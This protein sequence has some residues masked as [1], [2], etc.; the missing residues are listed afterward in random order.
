MTKIVI[1]EAYRSPIG[2]FGGAFQHISATEINSQLIAHILKQSGLQGDDIDEV[3]V[4]N[5]LQ[6]GLGQNPA[7][8]SAITGGVAESVPA[9]T[10]NKVCGS[11]LK[12]IQLAYQSIRAGDNHIVLAG[13]TE[14]MSQAPMLLDNGR[15][16]FKMGHQTLRDSMIHDGLTDAFHHYHMGITA[17]NIAEAYH[18]SRAQQDQFALESYQKA[19]RA[20]QTGGFDKEILPIEVPHRKKQMITVSKDEDVR[21]DT[22]LEVLQKLKPVFKKDGTVTAGNASGL[23]DGSA[24]MLVMTEEKAKT[25]NI[26]P[27]ATIEGFASSGVS[28]AM[29]GMGPVSAI[30]RLMEKTN[31]SLDE[32]DVFEINEAFAVQSL[33]VLQALNL[34]PERVNPKGGSTALGHPIGASGARVLVTL[35]HQLSDENPHGVASL[36]I[37]GGQGI[38][39]KVSHYK[40]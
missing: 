32:I 6:A 3:I 36:C 25:L 5:V 27:L 34:S 28:P 30:Q 20:Q 16:G 37:G 24:M 19:I 10:V 2:T 13:G 18:I 40:G 21:E 8:I 9:F 4:G 23:N 1:A 39:I 29:M 26:Q 38:A 15:F 14:N 7:R 33:A 22:T 35:L 12:A 17:E 31:H 11:G